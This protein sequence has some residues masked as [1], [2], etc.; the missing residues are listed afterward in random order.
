MLAKPAQIPDVLISRLQE[1][2]ISRSE[3]IT[4]TVRQKTVMVYGVILHEPEAGYYAA[5][6]HCLPCL[7]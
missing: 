4:L 5:Q 6:A 2:L 7:V 1:H 3:N